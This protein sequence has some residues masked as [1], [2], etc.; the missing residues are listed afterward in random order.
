M[1][2]RP[3]K[4]TFIFRR[5]LPFMSGMHA[6]VQNRTLPFE[7]AHFALQTPTS[8]LVAA[9]TISA[10]ENPPAVK[11]PLFKIRIRHHDKNLHQAHN[12]SR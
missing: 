9:D 8:S 7:P 3:F 2:A 10:Q 12:A 11:K 5:W 4:N 1:D 6:S